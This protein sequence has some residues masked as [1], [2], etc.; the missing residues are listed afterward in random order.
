MYEISIVAYHWSLLM[1]SDDTSNGRSDVHLHI[2]SWSPTR[3]TEISNFKNS[4][5][6]SQTIPTAAYKR[7]PSWVSSHGSSWQV[8]AGHISQGAMPPSGCGFGRLVSWPTFLIGCLI[9]HSLDA[10]GRWGGRCLVLLCLRKWLGFEEK[11]SSFMMA[12]M[13]ALSK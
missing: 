2:N 4:H 11:N 5:N 8:D 3:G 9:P 13:V 7:S 1:W 6:C 10:V 12:S